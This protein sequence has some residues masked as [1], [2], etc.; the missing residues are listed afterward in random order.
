MVLGV[1]ES[2]SSKTILL[3]V[4]VMVMAMAI[5]MC[6]EDEVWGETEA[7]QEQETIIDD[8]HN[9]PAKNSMTGTSSK[10]GG[11][12]AGEFL[13]SE[14]GKPGNPTT[15]FRIFRHMQPRHAAAPWQT[16]RNSTQLKT[17]PPTHPPLTL[18]YCVPT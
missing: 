11:V 12:A 4:G 7:C 1:F 8:R 6:G 2:S 5:L 14:A 13:R 17:K 15:A 10:A 3:E 9:K 18:A 16:Q